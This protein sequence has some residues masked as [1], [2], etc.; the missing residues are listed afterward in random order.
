MVTKKTTTGKGKTT[1]EKIQ[2]ENIVYGNVRIGKGGKFEQKTVH[3]T[4]L[5]KSKEQRELQ[6]N[7]LK[8]LKAAVR[9]KKIDWQEQISQPVPKV[10]NPYRPLQALDI[11]TSSFLSGRASLVQEI[12]PLIETERTVFLDGN[13]GVGKTSLLQA[14]LIPALLKK[15][16]M[17]VMVEAGSADLI[18]EIKRQFLPS[19]EML[20]FLKEMSLAEFVR[21]VS[22][23]LGKSKLLVLII[24]QFENFFKQDD[25]RLQKF[26]AEWLLS[27]KGG[28]LNVH[29]LFSIHSSFKYHLD[30]FSEEIKP[31]SLL[32]SVPPLTREAAREAILTPARHNGIQ[33][34]EPVIDEILDALGKK[35]FDPSQLQIVCH[36]LAGGTGALVTHWTNQHLQGC[37]GVD[38]ILSSYLDLV[39]GRLSPQ[40]QEPAWHILGTLVD[41]QDGKTTET[42]LA[43]QMKPY[44]LSQDDTDRILEGLRQYHLVEREP[45]YRLTSTS[46]RERVERWLD[47][48][49][50]REQARREMTQQVRSIGGSALR[51]LIGGALGFGLAY[52]ALPYVNRP[53]ALDGASIGYYAYNVALRALFGG[54]TGFLM[55]L[56]IDLTLAVRRGQQKSSHLLLG[57]VT[58]A[59]AFSFLLTTH[60]FLG[61]FGSDFGMMLLRSMAEGLLWG[62]VT[63]A[64]VV[65]VLIFKQRTWI[66]LPIVCLVSGL[67]LAVTDIV[68]KAMNVT[69][70]PSVFLAGVVMCL[71]VIGFTLM[72]KRPQN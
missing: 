66:A 56:V 52:I 14:G 9:Q 13:S 61:Y 42:W 64:G 50:A 38:G 33:I 28:A 15:E 69:S 44:G 2:A 17:P 65:W 23:E 72:G 36:T 68:L 8:D 10:G 24:D 54:I 46:L 71:A 58:G 49:S 12:L 63:G 60:T 41:N 32:K 35:E 40:D 55:I 27:T 22:D 34:D 62:S 45:V 5:S 16:H 20:D 3:Y 39:I 11:A 37:G 26:Q 30:L 19:I 53:T 59:I 1:P 57:A 48:Q 6:E 51:G 7:E 18:L 43:E 31:Y 70:L 47:G 29:W 4:P 21:R 25:T 67:T